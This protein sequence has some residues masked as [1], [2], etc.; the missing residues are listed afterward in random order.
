MLPALDVEIEPDQAG[1][2][3]SGLLQ[4][5]STKAMDRLGWRPRWEGEM[6]ERT[7]DWYR[8]YYQE[9]RVISATQLDDYSRAG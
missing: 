3:E 9:G 7:I 5:D 8:A 1:R 6:L 4:L 2:H